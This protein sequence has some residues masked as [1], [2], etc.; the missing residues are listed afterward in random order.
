MANARAD[1][2]GSNRFSL[3]RSRQEGPHDIVDMN[4]VSHDASGSSDRDRL[5]FQC[6]TREQ[7]NGTKSLFRELTGSVAVADPHRHAVKAVKKV[8]VLEIAL[9]HEL[10]EAESTQR[11]G[12]VEF[13]DRRRRRLTVNRPTRRCEDHTNAWM[14]S[15]R[16]K[17]LDGA[18][19]V[20][21]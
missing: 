16:L 18:D 10:G 8:V 5:T 7:G 17:Q 14:P 3:F 2:E 1:V 12:R 19:H 15:R 4:I 11:L 9:H 6:R 13:A 20:V 21:G